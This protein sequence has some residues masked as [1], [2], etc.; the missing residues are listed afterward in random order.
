M[1]TRPLP[2]LPLQALPSLL[3]AT[4]WPEG[5][6]PRLTDHVEQARLLR[7]AADHSVLSELIAEVGLPL[8]TEA[9]AL[10]PGLAAALVYELLLG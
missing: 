6:L 5:H 8:A 4:R 2:V 1:R 10:T 9:G 3:L 7:C